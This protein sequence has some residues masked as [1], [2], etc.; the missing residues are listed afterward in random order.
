MNLAEV[1]MV[2][3]DLDDT[4]AESKSPLAPEMARA[5][6]ELLEVSPVCVISGGRY[7]QFVSQVLAS[8]PEGTDLTRLHLMPTCGTRYVRFIDG[9]WHEVYAHEM[10]DDEKRQAS[11]A[12]EESARELGLWEDDALVSGPR[13]ED[14]G[15]QV[16]FSAL[17]QQAAVADKKR[18]DPDG[19]KRE[20]LRAV[21]A[22]RL[23]NLE[24]RA[25]GSTSIDVTRLGVDKA[26]G[27]KELAKQA[28]IGLEEILFVGDRLL[29]GGNDYPVLELGIACH[30]V[31]GPEET[32][33]YVRDLA[34]Q[35]AARHERG[36]SDEQ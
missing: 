20:R 3:F 22:A 12:L 4:L 13:I 2:A 1:R 34:P 28:G 11:S 30:A 19:A 8:L 10:S 15:T 24:V 7:E 32:V 6:S 35:L 21:V 33:E 29:P 26:Y 17:G 25:G 36:E 27:M 16:T 31:S 14:R 9:Q 5:L 23:P 18:W